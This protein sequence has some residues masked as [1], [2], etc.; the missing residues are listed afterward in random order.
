MDRFVDDIPKRFQP[1]EEEHFACDNAV[2]VL[3]NNECNIRSFLPTFIERNQQSFAFDPNSQDSYS[4][5]LFTDVD[6]IK[7]KFKPF[8]VFW[9][10]HKGYAIGPTNISRG[11]ALKENNGH[12]NF[13]LYDTFNNNPCDDFTVLEGIE[14]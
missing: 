4:L 12:I 6:S 11:I 14:E 3:I 13:Y 7:R 9:K 1:D 8:S 5:S 10:K 2:R